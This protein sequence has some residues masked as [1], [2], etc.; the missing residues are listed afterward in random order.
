MNHE[1]KE[2]QR[3]KS[4]RMVYF[5]LWRWRMEMKFYDVQAYDYTFVA[6]G[7]AGVRAGTS[8]SPI[9]RCTQPQ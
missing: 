3:H 1:R 7:Y 4:R 6:C 5:E 9:F 8:A 2:M